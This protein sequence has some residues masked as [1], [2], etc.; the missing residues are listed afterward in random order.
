MASVAVLR[1]IRLFN[2]LKNERGE[3]GGLE[4]FGRRK[5]FISSG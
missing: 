5:S 3:Q 2:I 1:T 4:V